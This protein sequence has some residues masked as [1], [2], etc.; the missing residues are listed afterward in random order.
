MRIAIH[1]PSAKATRG[2]L[3]LS[4]LMQHT[5]ARACI[6]SRLYCMPG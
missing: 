2:E 6:D 4:R 5:E 3:V 1:L